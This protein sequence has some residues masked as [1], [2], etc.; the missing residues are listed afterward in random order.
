MWAKG[1]SGIV[2]CN[3]LYNDVYFDDPLP[4]RVCVKCKFGDKEIPE[5]RIWRVHCTPLGYGEEHDRYF[6]STFEAFD[7]Y[8]SYN[9]GWAEIAGKPVL[10]IRDNWIHS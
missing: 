5:D 6:T 4:H 3:H 8:R 1:A 2:N 10:S 9:R 7:F